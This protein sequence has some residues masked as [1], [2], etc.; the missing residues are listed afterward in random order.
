MDV[1]GYFYFFWGWFFRFIVVGRLV[2]NFLLM[3]FWMVLKVG[4]SVG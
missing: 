4:V 2:G 1:I 3:V